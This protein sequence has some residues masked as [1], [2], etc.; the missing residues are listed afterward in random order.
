MGY[1]YTPNWAASRNGNDTYD[2]YIRRSFD[3]GQTWTR[4]KAGLPASTG[5][6]EIR[7]G[8]SVTTTDGSQEAPPSVVHAT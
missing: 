1:S 4:L 7:S 8:L 6:I 5:R 2:F 3:G